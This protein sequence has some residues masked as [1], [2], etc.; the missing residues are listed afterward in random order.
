MESH[1][2][3]RIRRI[4]PLNA[5]NTLIDIERKNEREHIAQHQQRFRW[6]MRNLSTECVAERKHSNAECATMKYK[7][8]IRLQ[9]KLSK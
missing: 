4:Y 6:M 5:P 2:L 8:V 1:P 9:G 7:H 3:L